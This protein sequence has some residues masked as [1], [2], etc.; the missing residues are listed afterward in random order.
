ME[1]KNNRKK[2]SNFLKREGFYV[3]L[4]VCLC[5]A[6]AVAAITTGNNKKAENNPQTS[7]NAGVN[8]Q[9][10]GDTT[11]PKKEVAISQNDKEINNAVQV[12]TNDKA[13][14]KA[15]TNKEL[16]VSNTTEP[17]FI[18]PVDGEIAMKYSETPV[19]WETSKT[20]RPN[21]GINIKAKVGTSVKAAAAGE[22]KSID[23]DGAFGTLI[24]IYHPESGKYT[25]YGNLDKEVKVSKGDKVTQ[26]QVIGKIGNSSLRGMADEIGGNFLYLQVLKNTKEDPQFSSENP[27]KYIKY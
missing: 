18:K 13:E 2:S 20:Y 8:S 1:N 26:G 19:W 16:E 24:T 27:E 25:C 5:I 17:K 21:F 3:V 22:V 12:K 6:A 14:N 15:S 10:K 23:N 4:F 7:Q 9:A 11:L